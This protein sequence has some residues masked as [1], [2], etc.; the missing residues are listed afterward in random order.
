MNLGLLLF[1]STF[2][3]LQ[4]LFY[5]IL[6]MKKSLILIIFWQ[7]C[8]W[9][10][11]Q[12][13]QKD[14]ENQHLLQINREPAR[15]SFIGF[16]KLIG[17]CSMSLNGLWKFNWTPTPETRV[18]DFY[19][20]DFNDAAWKFFPVPANWEVNGY[21][22]PIYISAGYPFKIDPPRISSVPKETYTTYKERNPVGQ[23]RRTFILPN[24]W[25]KNGQLFM[26]F[27]GVQ[28]AFYVWING[29]EAGYSQGSM[30]PSEFNIS[31]FIQAGENQIAVEVYKYCDGSYLEDQDMWRFGG[32]QRAVTLYKTPNITISDVTVITSLD[33]NYQNAILKIDP[34]LS[35][36][37]TENGNGYIVRARI[38][39]LINITTKASDIINIDHKAALMNEWNP[40]R[41]PR[42]TGRLKAEIENPLLWSAE[43][44][45]LYTLNLSLEDSTGKV[46]QNVQ[47][48]I[49]FRS[50]EIHDGQLLVNGKAVRLRGVNRH[51]NDPLLAKVMTEEVM[52][53]DIRLMKQA[54]INAVRTSHYPN[55]TRWYELCD[56]LG[57]YVMDEADIEEHGLRGKLASDPDWALAFLDRT[58]R[59]AER[60]KNHPSIIMWSLGN[61]AGYGPN[62]AA[63]SA[64]LKD[65]DP[66]RPVHYEGAQGLNDEPDPST[67]DVISR[68]YPRIKQEYLN[69]GVPENSD[70]ERPE[71][72]RWERLL[73]I[74]ERTNDN[75]PVLTSEYAH[76]MGNAMGNFQEYW[77]EIY[78][79]KRM[80]G[81]FIWDWVDQ[82]IYK[83]TDDNK[84]MLAYGGDFGDFPNS[85]AFCLNGVVMSNRETTAK[86]EEVKK[87]Y[88]PID[89]KMINNQ[90]RI[91]NRQH[92]SNLSQYKAIWNI[93]NYGKSIYKGEL[94]IPSLQAGDTAWIDSPHS[95]QALPV[96]DLQFDIA[97]VLKNDCNWANAGHIVAFEQFNIQA[98]KLAS[99]EF[100]NNGK[101]NSNIEN[102]L[103]TVAGRSF[104]A[105]W[106]VQTGSFIS[107]I[108]NKK[109]ILAQQSKEFENQPIIQAFRAPTDNDKGFGNWLAK[110]WINEGLNAPTVT[111]DSVHH[112]FRKDGAFVFDVIKTN[113]YKNSSI[114]THLRYLVNM[115]GE[116]DLT[117]NFLTSGKLPPLP[118]LG[119]ALAVNGQF[120]N[121]CWYGRGPFENYPDRKSAAN[122][123]FWSGNVSDQATKFPRPQDTGNKED[124]HFLSLS[125]WK[126]QGIKV[127][128]IGK[129]F[130]SSAL[131]YSV[132]DLA[133]ETHDCNLIPRQ[134]VILSIDCTVMGLGNS[135]CGP[136][137]L[138]KFAIEQK[139]HKL[140][141]RILVP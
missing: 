98:G 138:K 46:I 12:A 57:L 43:S 40:Q 115:K 32:I 68:F 108:Y 64:W 128:A 71:N 51:E 50:V 139:E 140:H 21:G 34:E 77:D 5:T 109:E 120:D 73:E 100:K 76:A 90:L 135:S 56:S 15:A 133:N 96:G 80:L 99:N 38:N 130:S 66:T 112:Y 8:I 111:I 2:N 136:G 132:N 78:S 97:F 13:Q 129:A 82:G 33:K 4:R 131:N 1:L 58:I 14:W 41:G 48:K 116:V 118:R 10:L 127:E 44:P 18:I 7:L 92:H 69:P 113:H 63:C 31:R 70:I 24:E 91:I 16:N 37:G 141:I 81:G 42:K 26:R 75:R 20:T 122:M 137:V 25:E 85:K 110:D 93:N 83:K 86:Y 106:N 102:N 124:V 123:G 67:V 87:V 126:K 3:W 117:C 119:I 22:T 89:L 27:D 30:E 49:G 39:K 79:N 134:E 19:K 45:N 9:G 62:F 11:L 29:Q 103:I 94:Q 55:V 114:K 54:N 23:Y 53:K 84:Q 105:S 107:L 36:Y 72:A 101:L 65:F 59:M 61:E 60:D 52:L 88:Q 28:S 17:D 95:K 74:A 121:F 125:N 35:V 104:S 6:G 47:Q